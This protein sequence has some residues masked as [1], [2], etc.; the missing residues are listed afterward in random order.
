MAP[1]GMCSE[2]LDQ[3]P[4]R[5]LRRS[6]VVGD[7]REVRVF[8]SEFLKSLVKPEGLYDSFAV[9]LDDHDLPLTVEEPRP[10]PSA[11]GNPRFPVLVVYHPQDVSYREP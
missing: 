9:S 3:N 2:P 7:R 11:L 4:F 6:T 10:V 5:V 8:Q 1:L